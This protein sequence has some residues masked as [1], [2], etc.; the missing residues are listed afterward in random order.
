MR[1]TQRGDAM[2]ERTGFEP[3]RQLRL[4]S[5]WPV[6]AALAGDDEQ[7]AGTIDGG[8]V[9]GR[10]QYGMGIGK[11]IAMQIDD[12]VGD[13]LAPPQALIPTAIERGSGHGARR[14]PKGWRCREWRRHRAP[15]R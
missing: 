8:I 15:G 9:K 1:R 13:D 12:S 7:H 11:R 5:R 6:A 14:L 3:V 10:R 2:A 4:D